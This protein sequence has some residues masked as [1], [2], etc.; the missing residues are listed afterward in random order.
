MKLPAGSSKKVTWGGGHS[1][2]WSGGVRVQKSCHGCACFLGF[3]WSGGAFFLFLFFFF[4]RNS[5]GSLAFSGSVFFL[6]FFF[7]CTH[8]DLEV[9]AVSSQFD[10]STKCIV[11]TCAVETH[12]KIKWFTVDM[13]TMGDVEGLII[14]QSQCCQLTS[15]KK[16]KTLARLFSFLLAK[17]WPLEVD[18]YVICCAGILDYKAL[19]MVTIT[20]CLVWRFFLLLLFFLWVL[21]C[22]LRVTITF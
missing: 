16:N 15:K 14:K 2:S 17:G 22:C 12:L 13:Y 6:F 9:E 20:E 3:Y 5:C 1:V 21:D 8:C 10:C 4:L 11:I 19:D 18:Q 7:L